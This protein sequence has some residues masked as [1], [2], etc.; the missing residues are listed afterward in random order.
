[1][2]AKKTMKTAAAGT[3]MAGAFG[4]A[5][6]GLG[7]G[8]SLAKPNHPG[9]NPPGP[10]VAG[11]AAQ[12]HGPASGSWER[13]VD[14]NGYGDDNE[15]GDDNGT[16]GVLS[17][18]TAPGQN[19][20]GPPGQVM[21]MPTI[22]GLPNPFFNVPPGHWGTVNLTPTDFGLPATWMPEGQTTALPLVF[23]PQTFTWGVYVDGQFVPYVAPVVIPT[24]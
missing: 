3:A 20:I 5:V 7:S 12:G 18:L 8:V 19:P 6:M 11:H 14:Q 10:S 16:G 24:P 4:F 22:N 2:D 1:M 15:T 13:D 9:P 17:P 23:N 21:K